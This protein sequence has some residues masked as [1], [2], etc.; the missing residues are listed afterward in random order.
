MDLFAFDNTLNLLPHDGTVHYFG[1]VFAPSVC[2][3]YFDYLLKYIEWKHD[4][5][6]IYGKHIKTKRKIAWY[7]DQNYHYS[8]SNTTKQALPWTKDLI[9]LKGIVEEK[10][11]LTFNSCLINLYHNGDE[12]VAWHSDDEY[13]LDSRAAIASLS[14]GAS[15]KFSFKHKSSKETVSLELE[16]GSLLIMKGETQRHW[17]HALPKTKKV[18][19]PRINLTFRVMK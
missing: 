6:I 1:S 2:D 14:F 11:Q 17:L 7:G 4:E 12:G 19:E 9:D 16:A 18:S 5:V 3:D 13:S 8:Y 15:R 10:A